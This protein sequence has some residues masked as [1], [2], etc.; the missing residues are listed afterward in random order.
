M[1]SEKAKENE[2]KKN[3]EPLFRFY[4]LFIFGIFNVSFSSVWLVRKL[5]KIRGKNPLT[6]SI[7]KPTYPNICLLF[8]PKL[9]C[10]KN[11]PS[12]YKTLL[13]ELLVEVLVGA[14]DGGS[15]R[16][17]REKRIV[18]VS[19]KNSF[20]IKVC[21]MEKKEEVKDSLLM[22]IQ[23]SRLTISL[24]DALLWF[25]Y[26]FIL[27]KDY[28]GCKLSYFCSHSL[29]FVLSLPIYIYRSTPFLLFFFH[30]NSRKSGNPFLFVY[31]FLLL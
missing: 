6:T 18:R 26:L 5:R 22:W 20:G 25:I 29:I 10:F 1:V 24:K 23:K 30:H 4:S 2:G 15:R 9:N 3:H 19:D 28:F 17:W 27:N 13:W 8:Y 11:L 7:F 31:F 16:R 14:T 21:W 12:H